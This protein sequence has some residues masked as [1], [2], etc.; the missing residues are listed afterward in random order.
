[1]SASP[2]SPP[3]PLSP[4]DAAARA[5]YVRQIRLPEIGE[6]GQARL[7][8]SEVV[9][10]GVG[11]ARNVEASYVARAGLRVID[12]A[13]PDKRAEDDEYVATLATLGLADPAARDVGDGAL[14]ALLAIRGALAKMENAK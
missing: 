11:D 5:R 12:M 14:R 1:M 9:I 6:A 8:A 2:P 13:T 3:S 4:L 7:C 10:G